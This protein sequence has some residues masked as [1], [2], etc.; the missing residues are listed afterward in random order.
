MMQEDLINEIKI[1]RLNKDNFKQTSLDNFVLNQKVEECYRKINGKYELTPVSYIEDWNLCERREKA[2]IIIDSIN[3]GAIAFAAVHD[4]EIIAFA[5]LLHKLFGSKKQYAD[6]AEFYVSEK[7]RRQK[8]GEKLFWIM[9]REGR[10]IGAK[11]L[12]ISA[13][14]AKESISAYKK[15]GCTFA[16][17]PDST[18]IEKE[19]YDLQLEYDLTPRIYKVED[20]EN[21]INLL[22]L[23]DEQLEMVER[24]LNKS[25]MYVL[26]DCGVKGEI[27]VMELDNSVLEIKNL[28]VLP[29]FQHCGYGKMLV[30]FV[31]EKYKGQFSTVLV[32]TGDS[33]LTIPFYEK[34]GFVKSH[35][36]KNFFTENYDHPIIEEGIQL[37]DMIY[38]KKSLK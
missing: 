35:K 30:E 20:K 9:C 33:P 23:A 15:Y 7:Y 16:L 5:L 11:K 10:K 2:N 31:C 27:T 19:P 18:H 22:L 29:G 24:Y 4:N 26:F 14:S 12:Y 38:L 8:I 13:H 21:Y 17:E 32:G 3:N 34:C 1:I 37:I 36:I 28:A 25:T 6:L